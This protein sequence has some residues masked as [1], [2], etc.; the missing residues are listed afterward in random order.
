[1]H[2]NQNKQK[3]IRCRDIEYTGHCRLLAR[4]AE[5]AKVG[6]AVSLSPAPCQGSG[7]SLWQNG[8]AVPVSAI[9]FEQLTPLPQGGMLTSVSQ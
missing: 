2:K 8:T 5:E 6:E 9:R 3:Y 7:P 4:T 1:M